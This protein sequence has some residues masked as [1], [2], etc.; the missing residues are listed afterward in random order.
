[1]RYISP[2]INAVF[3]RLLPLLEPNARRPDP[4]EL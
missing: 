2:P 1:V 3:R 4:A